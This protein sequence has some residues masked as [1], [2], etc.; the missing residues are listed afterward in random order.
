[1]DLWDKLWRKK[2]VPHIAEH[3]LIKWNEN[4]QGSLI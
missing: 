2:Y 4:A 3:H 1:M